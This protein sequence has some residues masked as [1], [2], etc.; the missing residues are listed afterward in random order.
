MVRKILVVNM[1]DREQRATRFNLIR[2]SKRG[3]IENI[4]V[5]RAGDVVFVPSRKDSRWRRILNG[6][7]DGVSIVSLAVLLGVL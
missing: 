3:D 5:L 4:P 2:F 7:R 1:S 6:F